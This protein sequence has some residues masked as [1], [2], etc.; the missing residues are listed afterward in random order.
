MKNIRYGIHMHKTVN[1]K[2]IFIL[3]KIFI[4]KFKNLFI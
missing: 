1:F 3:H 4:I 2:N